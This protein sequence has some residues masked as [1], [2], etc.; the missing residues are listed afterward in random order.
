L[1]GDN[2]SAIVYGQD[3]AVTID[4]VVKGQGT[5]AILNSNPSSPSIVNNS[6]AVDYT[7][8]SDVFY[9]YRYD[10]YRGWVGYDN[11]SISTLQNFQAGSMVVR[12]D[13][14][15]SSEDKLALLVDNNLYINPL[16]FST[17]YRN[18]N[19][20]DH[21]FANTLQNW[22]TNNIRIRKDNNSRLTTNEFKAAFQYLFDKH[23]WDFDKMWKAVGEFGIID[24]YKANVESLLSFRILQHD[25]YRY[26]KYQG[27]GRGIYFDD[28]VWMGSYD[29]PGNPSADHNIHILR[30]PVTVGNTTY[31]IQLTATKNTNTN[32]KSN[33]R[34]E[35]YD[36][37]IGTNPPNRSPIYSSDL[38]DV[39]RNAA[40]GLLDYLDGTS[41]ENYITIGKLAWVMQAFTKQDPNIIKDVTPNVGQ[42]RPE[43]L[44][45]KSEDFANSRL[46]GL[47]QSYLNYLIQR[48]ANNRLDISDIP[49]Y[50]QN[51][52][53]FLYNGLVGTSINVDG[54]GAINNLARNG[55]RSVLITR[56]YTERDV[57]LEG[58]VFVGNQLRARTG[59]NNNLLFQG[60]LI[61]GNTRINNSGNVHIRGVRNTIFE[62]DLNSIDLNLLNGTFIRLIPILYRQESVISK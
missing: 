54:N 43:N 30:I 11:S 3:V 19:W 21:I 9:P 32:N 12:F 48:N 49:N 14:V 53:P 20:F 10:R 46:E 5:F 16:D 28:R 8:N 45:N 26:Y 13:Q 39:D 31:T 23:K 17:Q 44:R 56:G 42:F 57:K 36:E 22:A 27:D 1:G 2:Q 52:F 55:I 60:N 59:L 4:G 25:R 34:L 29:D 47:Y 35:V 50:D 24:N 61:V 41:A 6:F 38:V 37:N 7:N 51:Y 33:L 18:L 62:F 58:M 40:L 15:K